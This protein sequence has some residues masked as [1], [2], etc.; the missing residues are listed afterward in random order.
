MMNEAL[1]ISARCILRGGF[2]FSSARRAPSTESNSLSE[3][4]MWTVVHIYQ[5]QI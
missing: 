2:A 4:E 3:D 1:N 5:V